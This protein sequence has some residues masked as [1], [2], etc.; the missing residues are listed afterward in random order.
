ML[1]YR[2]CTLPSNGHSMAYMLQYLAS[3]WSASPKSH[4]YNWYYTFVSVE[5]LQLFYSNF[6]QSTADCLQILPDIVY[7]I[8]PVFKTLQVGIFQWLVLN[9]AHNIFFL[10]SVFINKSVVQ[11]NIRKY[12]LFF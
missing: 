2:A 5:F 4:K 9:Y 6:V 10:A 1:S 7:S 3:N 12:C 11:S 8:A